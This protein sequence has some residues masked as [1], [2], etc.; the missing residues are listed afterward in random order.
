MQKGQYSQFMK[1]R[2]KREFLQ[3]I[4]VYNYDETH[5]QTM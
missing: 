1:K 2:Q 3:F 5:K 4:H